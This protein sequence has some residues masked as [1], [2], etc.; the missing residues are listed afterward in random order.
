MNP[1]SLAAS[2]ATVGLLQLRS[3]PRRGLAAGGGHVREICGLRGPNGELHWILQLVELR[4]PVGILHLADEAAHVLAGIGGPQVDVGPG[5]QIGL[6]KERVLR[7]TGPLLE[8][9]R[10]RLRA[11]ELSRILVLSTVTSRARPALVFADLHGASDL[12]EGVRAVVV[13]SGQVSTGGST[14]SAMEALVL[15][16][17]MTGD[18]VVARGPGIVADDARVLMVLG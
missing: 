4:G 11:A 10:P 8:L 3:L 17:A 16:S 6:R 12:P 2:S 7:H 14:A 1:A 18:S 15:P 13:R 9:R 5:A